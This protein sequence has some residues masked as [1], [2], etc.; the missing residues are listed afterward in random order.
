MGYYV[1]IL[2]PSERVPSIARIKE[3]LA[4]ADLAATL[5]L[6]AGSEESWTEFMLS[7]ADG[8]RI[9]SIERDSASSGDL[10]AREIDFFLEQIAD[11][12]PSSAAAWLAEYLPTVKTIYAFQVLS[13]TYGKNGWDILGN[14]QDTVIAEVGGIVHADLEG[15]SDADGYHILWQFSDSVTGPCLMG[16]LKDGKWVH[17]EMDLGDRK[18][19][20]AFLRGEV[21]EGAKMAD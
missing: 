1:R 7:H 9:A 12:Q 20:A 4:I 13:G 16:V 8:T 17:F 15:F 21:P 14:V 19:R 10:V 2:S 11:G 18:H 3:E 5:D 6:D